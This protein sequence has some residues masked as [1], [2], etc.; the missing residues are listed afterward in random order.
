MKYLVQQKFRLTDQGVYLEADTVF[1]PDDNYARTS[2]SMA[3]ALRAGWLRKITDAE[4][5]Q[6]EA[7]AVVVEPVKK[8][9]AAAK[10]AKKLDAPVGVA[11]MEPEDLAD[12]TISGDEIL[13]ARKKRREARE[14]RRSEK[15]TAESIKS[16]VKKKARKK[17]IRKIKES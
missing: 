12:E 3:A 11:E 2:R 9:S 10:A 13:A 1:E 4:A 16:E 8:K 7:K 15:T 6:V 14:A 17:R 5:E